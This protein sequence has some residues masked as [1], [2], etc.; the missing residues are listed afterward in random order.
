MEPKRL[1][2]SSVTAHRTSHVFCSSEESMAL[3]EMTLLLEAAPGVRRLGPL[4]GWNLIEKLLEAVTLRSGF[5]QWSVGSIVQRL[6]VAI[7]SEDQAWSDYY[8]VTYPRRHGLDGD[9][10]L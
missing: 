6:S 1:V 5:R 4:G 8:G 9:L 10:V 3:A 2:V 7:Q